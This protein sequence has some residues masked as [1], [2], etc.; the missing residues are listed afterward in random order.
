MIKKIIFGLFPVIFLT[1]FTITYD[2]EIEDGKVNEK[3]TVIEEDVNLAKEENEVGESFEDISKMYGSSYDLYTSFYNLYADNPDISECISNCSIY[4]K[5]YIDDGNR[6]GFILSHTFSFKDYGDSSLANEIIPGF[7]TILDD[8]TLQ[9]KSGSSWNFVN[10]YDNLEKLEINLKTTY[11]V[12]KVN[13]KKK[14][15]KYT[16]TINRDSTQNIIPLS[17]VL[18]I[19]NEDNKESNVP[20]WLIILLLVLVLGIIIYYFFQKRKQE[21][22]I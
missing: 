10:G 22:S 8:K 12:D 9:I 6:V 16:W 19:K 14:S 4:D 21:N 3:L 11:E 18:N 20:L 17:I 15:N 5:E 1:G 2:V 13:G 7:Q